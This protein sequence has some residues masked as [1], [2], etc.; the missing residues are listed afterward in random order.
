MRLDNVNDDVYILQTFAYRANLQEVKSQNV[1]IIYEAWCG[2]EAKHL[3]MHDSQ[4]TDMTNI[5]L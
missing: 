5:F 3:W 1:F 4:K 2:E